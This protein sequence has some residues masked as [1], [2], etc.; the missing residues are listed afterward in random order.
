M[1]GIRGGKL[2]AQPIE[3]IEKD[4][5]LLERLVIALERLAECADE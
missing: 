1:S 2:M 5:K 3:L 4:R